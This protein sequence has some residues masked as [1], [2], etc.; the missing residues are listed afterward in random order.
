MTTPQHPPAAP[1]PWTRRTP[2]IHIGM[3]KTATK[4][5]QW[6]LFAAHPEIYYLGRFDGGDF[7][8]YSKLDHCRNV[9][10]QK[11]MRE[12]AYVKVR[13]PAFELCDEYYADAIAPAVKD[14]RVPVWSWESYSTDTL[15]MRQL[16]ASNLKRVFGD[17]NILM[18]IRHPIRLIQSAYMQFIRA[19]N[20]GKRSNYGRP[21][22]LPSIDEWIEDEWNLDILHHLQYAQTL[23]AYVDQFGI[24]HVHVQAFESLQEDP[25]AFFGRICDIL[26]VDRQIGLN[27]VEGHRD[28]TAWNRDQ[29]QR[30][31]RVRDNPLLSLYF[32]YCGRR[33]KH[34]LLGLDRQGV[35]LGGAQKFSPTIDAIWKKRIIERT[36]E[37]NL[38]LQD[39]FGLALD[40]YGYFTHEV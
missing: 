35:P 11:L 12:I 27:L 18:T 23:A 33:R 6:R 38:W 36:R 17:A 4:T 8:K 19:R 13:A 26:G 31:Q 1:Q 24:E 22:F 16:R 29:I 28:N 34:G 2:L 14:G 32:R 9:T 39:T 40:R 37:S 30:L 20:I 21:P 15:E 10:V 7:R 25:R 5:L 3:P